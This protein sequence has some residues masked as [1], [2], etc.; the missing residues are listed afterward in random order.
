MSIY[1]RTAQEPSRDTD[2]SLAILARDMPQSLV[3][4]VTCLLLSLIL[5]KVFVRHKSDLD[6]IY[7][8]RP[9]VCTV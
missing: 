6:P 9:K 7:S 5:F 1:S 8:L 3:V 2:F 4:G